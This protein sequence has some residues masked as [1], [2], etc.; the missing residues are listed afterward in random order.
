[1]GKERLELL[2]AVRQDGWNL[3]YA[4][5]KLQNDRE[6]VMEAVKKTG[7]ALNFAS[8]ELQVELAI[9]NQPTHKPYKPF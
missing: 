5:K 6:V 8:Q 2:T 1:M 3:E 7:W 4:S 9:N